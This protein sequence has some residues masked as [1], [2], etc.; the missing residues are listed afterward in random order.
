MKRFLY[1]TV[2]IILIIVCMAFAFYCIE[3]YQTYEMSE[4][5]L[6][7]IMSIASAIIITVNSVPKRRPSR[8]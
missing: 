5:I 8:K 7:A 6:Y 3:D 4:S 2:S 1:N